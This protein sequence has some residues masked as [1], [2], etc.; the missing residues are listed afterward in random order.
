MEVRWTSPCTR[1]GH[2]FVLAPLLD[3]VYCGKCSHTY[4]VEQEAKG[5]GKGKK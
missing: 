4:L 1:C 5:K 2:G 3:G